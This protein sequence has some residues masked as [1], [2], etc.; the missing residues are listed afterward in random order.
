LTAKFGAPG[1]RCGEIKAQPQ[2]SL[3]SLSVA[4]ATFNVGRSLQPES[5]LWSFPLDIVDDLLSMNGNPAR[6]P[7]QGSVECLVGCAKS[8][9]KPVIGMGMGSG[10]TKC[11]IHP[12]CTT[13]HPLT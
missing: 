7:F 6:L 3:V 2:A 12:P 13:T 10:A 1:L 11:E 5:R 4:G 8:W 9:K